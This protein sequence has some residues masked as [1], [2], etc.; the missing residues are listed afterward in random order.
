MP[1]LKGLLT[2]LG[3]GME[4]AAFPRPSSLWEGGGAGDEGT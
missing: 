2:P 3:A 4:T 1:L